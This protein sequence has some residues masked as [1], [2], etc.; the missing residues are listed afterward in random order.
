MLVSGAVLCD[1]WWER[2]A[3]CC[4]AHHLQVATQLM[5]K[6]PALAIIPP[7]A[8]ITKAKSLSMGTKLQMQ[9][10]AG[11]RAPTLVLC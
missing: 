1:C 11:E 10:A 5:I 9:T 3:P 7:N 2:H 6:H 8:T 4:T